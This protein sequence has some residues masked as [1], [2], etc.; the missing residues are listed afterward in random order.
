MQ[1]KH[2]MFQLVWSCLSAAGTAPPAQA[3]HLNDIF[4]EK[5]SWQT[6]SCSSTSMFSGPGEQ[7]DVDDRYGVRRWCGCAQKALNYWC[8]TPS[9]RL[10]PSIKL[11]FSSRAASLLGASIWRII[12]IDVLFGLDRYRHTNH[13]RCPQHCSCFNVTYMSVLLSVEVPSND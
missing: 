11:I 3:S 9:C 5:S 7:N 8:L 1:Q 4:S 6:C 10:N 2:H 13:H 12:W